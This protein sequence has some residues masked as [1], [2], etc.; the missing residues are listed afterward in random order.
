MPDPGRSLF[1][2]RIVKFA[3]IQDTRCETGRFIE[4]NVSLDRW[5]AS[6]GGPDLLA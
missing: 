2:R 1:A 4:L 3:E 6:F 5:R